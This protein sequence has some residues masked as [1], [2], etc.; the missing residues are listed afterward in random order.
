MF[1]GSDSFLPARLCSSKGE[2]VEKGVR[3]LEK[4][5]ECF[6]QR[7]QW[8]HT[9]LR[10]TQGSLRET[11]TQRQACTVQRHTQTDTDIHTNT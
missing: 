9:T 6:H 10:Q 11:L 8:K 4:N 7:G 5:L 3:K 1:H 2:H